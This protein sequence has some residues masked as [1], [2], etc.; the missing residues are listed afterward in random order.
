MEKVLNLSSRKPHSASR[1][2]KRIYPPRDFNRFLRDM[3]SSS[4]NM[5]GTKGEKLID[6]QFSERIMMAVTEV[7]GCRYCTYF[8][9][10][11]A[12]KAGLDKE[13]IRETFSGD[14]SQA[15]DE[16]LPRCCSHSTMRKAQAGRRA[17]WWTN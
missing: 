15:P 16:E 17:R 8:H 10:Q 7:N 5:R 1:Y 14:F 6:S 4:G 9:T 11:V 12:L 13:E 2:M 3:V